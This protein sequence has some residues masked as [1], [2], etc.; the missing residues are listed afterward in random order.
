[1]PEEKQES[2][3]LGMLRLAGK[4]DW[5]SM[6]LILT[7]LA[8]AGGAVWNKIELYLQEYQQQQIEVQAQNSDAATGGAYDALATRL[9]ELF[10]RIE[11]L[12]AANAIRSHYVPIPV[13]ENIPP[14]P[15]TIDLRE[16]PD[17]VVPVEPPPEPVSK[18]FKNAR[19]PEFQAVQQAAR[20]D[21][22][23]FLEQ[24]KAE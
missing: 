19:L 9:D 1:M 3:V 11:A 12:E 16:D 20:Q 14:L 17:N 15:K 7:A 18:R 13:T 5:R 24:V 22:E 10:M 2:G 6:L 23:Q 21:L 4:V 8:G